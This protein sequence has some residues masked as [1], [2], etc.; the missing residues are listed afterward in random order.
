MLLATGLQL[1]RAIG[2]KKLIPIL[3]IGGVALGFMMSRG[4]SDTGDEAEAAADA[5]GIGVSA[6]TMVACRTQRKSSS[7]SAKAGD[8][9]RRGL[10]VQ[11]L[12]SLEYW[13]T[14]FRG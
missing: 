8:P 9:V 4:A 6:P 2:V 12:T 3:A 10:S 14:R 1:V 7:S 11:S 5:G 13:I